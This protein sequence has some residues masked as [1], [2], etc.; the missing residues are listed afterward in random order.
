MYNINVSALKEALACVVVEKWQGR[1]AVAV[2][3]AAAVEVEVLAKGA[4]EESRSSSSSSS[5][6]VVVVVPAKTSND[7]LCLPSARAMRE[8]G[9]MSS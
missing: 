3:A 2:A 5:S 9:A 4:R 7:L 6:L 8:R 1:R